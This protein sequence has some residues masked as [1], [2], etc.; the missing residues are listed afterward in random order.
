[1]LINNANKTLQNVADNIDTDVFDPLLHELYNYIMLTDP[2]HM[3]RGDENICSDGVRQAAKQEQDLTKQLQFMQ[4]INNPA[5]LQLVGPGETARVLQKIADNIGME[6]KIKQPG[7]TPGAQPPGLPPGVMA[8]P[9]WPGN[10][11]Q[12]MQMMGGGAPGAP[13]AG[14]PAAGYNPSG[15]NQA[16][17]SGAAPPGAGGVQGITPAPQVAPM[18]TVQ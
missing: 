3:L 4:L 10:W 1:M 15:A 2:T 7:D 12:A 8:P 14:S 13:P 9:G 18:N 5:Y 16:P 17:P 11:Q 6:V